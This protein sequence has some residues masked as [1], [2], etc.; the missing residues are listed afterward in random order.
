M[1]D[2]WKSETEYIVVVIHLHRFKTLRVPPVGR[3]E[4]VIWRSTSFKISRVHLV[5][6]GFCVLYKKKE[7]QRKRFY[8]YF[9]YLNPGIKKCS[10]FTPQ[11]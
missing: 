4:N 9:L 6:C 2:F 7:T 10:R 8:G 1:T 5:R 11:L 3:I